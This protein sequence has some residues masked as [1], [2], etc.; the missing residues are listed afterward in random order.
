[1][2]RMYNMSA[3]Y[4]FLLLDQIYFIESHYNCDI[5]LLNQTIREYVNK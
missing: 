5:V 4:N 1:M 3:H 2:N